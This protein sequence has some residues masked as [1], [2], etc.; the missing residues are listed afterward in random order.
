[1]RDCSSRLRRLFYFDWQTLNDGEKRDTVLL[2]VRAS[3]MCEGIC[4]LCHGHWRCEFQPGLECVHSSII[5]EASALVL[6]SRF[7]IIA[8][9]AT[10]IAGW[11]ERCV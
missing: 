4:R 7:L 1:M 11:K 6:V 2:C 10:N 5:M 8:T 3:S 9:K